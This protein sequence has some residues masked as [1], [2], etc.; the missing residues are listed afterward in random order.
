MSERDGY[1][2]G[3]FCWVDL[4]V[5]DVDAATAF[6]GDLIGWEAKSAGPVD[7]AGGYGFF[8]YKGKMV[9]GYGPTQSEHQP[10]AWSSYITV[11]DIDETTARV[12][13]A[14]GNVLMEPMELPMES[15]RVAVYRDAEGAFINAIQPDRHAGAELVNEVGT[16]TWTNLGTRDFDKAQSFYGHVFGWKAERSPEAPPELPYLMWHVEGQK[17]DEGLAGLQIL[18]DETPPQVP[19]HWMVYFA[20]EDA[21]AAVE[22]TL[23]AG[24]QVM[25]PPLKIPV[26]VMALL[27]DPQ[28]AAFAIIQPDYPEGR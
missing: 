21:D 20:V 18:G 11:A 17:W 2:P 16:W 14:S 27:I 4:A 24:G 5:K 6:Y 25:V 26:G 13:E 3:E 12:R 19:P 7:E 23:A 28:S 8:A 9:A 15:G 10:P 1:K 22:K